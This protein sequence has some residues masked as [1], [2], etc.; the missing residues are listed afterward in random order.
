M[1]LRAG[2]ILYREILPLLGTKP[3][4]PPDATAHTEPYFTIARQIQNQLM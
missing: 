3:D 2:V 1:G 4:H